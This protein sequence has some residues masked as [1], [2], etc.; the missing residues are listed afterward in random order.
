ML[1]R[2]SNVVRLANARI[3]LPAT[4]PTFVVSTDAGSAGTIGSSTSG[5][6]RHRPLLESPYHKCRTG[7][8]V[9]WRM[10]VP[11]KII[12]EVGEVTEDKPNV[13]QSCVPAHRVVVV[14]VLNTVMFC[15]LADDANAM[16][17]AT[18]NS[19]NCPGNGSSRLVS[20]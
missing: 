20:A 1:C 8:P 11:C 4:E 10:A 2:K 12:P 7:L 18:P 6:T 13:D 17:K 9:S 16:S 19:T 15:A 5:S 3:R 14:A